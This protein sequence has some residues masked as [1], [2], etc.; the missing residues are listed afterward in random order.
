MHF[1]RGPKDL[2]ATPKRSPG[3]NS[4]ELRREMQPAEIS[5]KQVDYEE[6]ARCVGKHKASQSSQFL[7]SESTRSRLSLR[8]KLGAR[9]GGSCGAAGGV[10]ARSSTPIYE[11]GLKGG[12][13]QVFGPVSGKV[14]FRGHRTKSSLQNRG[15]QAI[16]QSPSD[17]EIIGHRSLEF[18]G[19]RV[20]LIRHPRKRP[21]MGP[22]G[23]SG[24]IKDPEA[25]RKISANDSK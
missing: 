23:G 3:W 17:S 15:G 2:W 4:G 25:Q 6:S 16:R 14:P 9:Y 24:K 21:L 13:R 5:P 11:R 18:P 12:V 10:S 20:Q 8:H 22:E 19:K 7:R 1:D